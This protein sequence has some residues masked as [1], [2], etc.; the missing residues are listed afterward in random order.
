LERS[1]PN[2]KN[3]LKLLTLEP[4]LIDRMSSSDRE[5]LQELGNN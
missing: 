2:E 3:R 4:V 1:D 5:M